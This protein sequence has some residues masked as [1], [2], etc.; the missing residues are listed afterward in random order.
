MITKTPRIDLAL[1]AC[2]GMSDEE[3]AQRGAGGYKAMRDRKRDYAAKFRTLA[4]GLP[5]VKKQIDASDTEISGLKQK[6]AVAESQL[7]QLKALDAPMD[8]TSASAAA[9]LM[10]KL[11]K[12]GGTASE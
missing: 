4:V 10:A 7:A 9:A 3:L 1:A 5:A 2:E 12:T 8:D 11:G 6:L